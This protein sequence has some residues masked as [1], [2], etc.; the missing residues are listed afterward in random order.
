MNQP[1]GK[2]H[3]LTE[4]SVL[5]LGAMGSVLASTLLDAGRSVT[6][7]NRTPGRAPELAARGARVV[8]SVRAAVTASPVVVACLL[9]HSSVQA[10]LGPVADAL[11]G[12]TLVNVTTTTPNESRALASWAADHGIDH[13]DGAIMAVPAMIGSGT[14]QIFYSGSRAAYDRLQPTFDL[15][16]ASEF[17]GADAGRAALVDLAMLSGMYQMFTGFFHGA[18]M[19]AAMGMS[20]PEFAA[21][22][23]PFLAAMTQ[24]L[25]A[26]AKVIEGGDYTVPGQQSLHFSDLSHLVQASA[27]E[28]VDPAPIAAVQTLISREIAAGRGEEGLARV[29]EGLRAGGAA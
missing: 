18:A 7:W 23:A 3:Q 16:A 1:A 19:V 4:V 6:V 5:G 26:Y 10:T 28:G 12:R 17:H 9:D 20:A 24:E 29:Y 22:Q 25:A 8:D 13:L 2:P 11:R 27:E 15:W 21:R 14:G